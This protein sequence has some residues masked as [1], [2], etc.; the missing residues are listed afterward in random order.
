M[1]AWRARGDRDLL[2]R[3]LAVAV[4]ALAALVLLFW[5]TRTGPAAQMMAMP[6]AVAVAFILAPLAFNQRDRCCACR[7]RVL[8]VLVGLGALVPLVDN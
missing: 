4:P 2:R 1:L 8:A 6:G 7:A 3:T 5:Q